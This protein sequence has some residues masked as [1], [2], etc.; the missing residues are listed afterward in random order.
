MFE[1]TVSDPR[2]AGDAKSLAT[3]RVDVVADFVCPW[4]YLGKRRLDTALAAVHGPTDVRWY[5]FQL[6]PS[7]PADGMS[8]Q[9][10]LSSRF[11]SRELA[12]V[13]L[14]RLRVAGAAAGI[15]FD[16]ESIERVPNTVN[17]H[18]LMYL[19][20]SRGLDTSDLADALMRRFFEH[21]VDISDPDALVAIG[22]QHGLGEKEIRAGLASEV[23]RQAVL[24]QEAQMRK[25]GVAGV[26]AFLVNKRIFVSGAQDADILLSVFD[27]AM[28]GDEEE[29]SASASLH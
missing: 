23:T 1:S 6:N 18:V 8:M 2:T 14:D 16:F 9:D 25:N 7:M 17:A 10:Y 20:A 28:F 11:G 22:L 26:P 12:D 15:G 13:G 3:L 21:G 24:G 4:C 19:A 27:R 5:P 29:Q